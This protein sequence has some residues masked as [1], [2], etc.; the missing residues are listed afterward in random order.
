MRPPQ[1]S[2]LHHICIVDEDEQFRTLFRSILQQ[3]RI[4]VQEASDGQSALRLIATSPYRLVVVLAQA[5]SERDGLTVLSAMLADASLAK[6][7]AYL[8]L[9]VAPRLS[10]TLETLVS[11]LKVRVIFQPEDLPGVLQQIGQLAQ[12]LE[13]KRALM[14]LSR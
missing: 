11:L 10:P 2:Q 1:R 4:A 5:I 8:L 13:V 7:H 14:A 12:G 9:S 3:H 6:Y